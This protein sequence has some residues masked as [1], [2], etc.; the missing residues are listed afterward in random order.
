MS[1][2]YDSLTQAIQDYT[3]NTETSFVA[4]IDT[5]IKSSEERILKTVQLDLF[6]RNAAGLMTA[7]NKYLAKPSDFLS[8]FSLSLKTGG[9]VRFVEFKD[10]SFVQTFS[11]DESITGTPEYYSVFDINNFILGP[12]PNENL[13]VEI[14]YFY[15]PTSLTAGAGA[16]TTWLSENAEL[17]LL[18]GSLI[19]AYI[20]M[21]GESDILQMYDKR[22]QES[23]V[24]LKLFGESKENTQDYR[25]GR[26][27]L[28]KQ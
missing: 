6:K 4:N 22:F 14:H 1:F 8:P 10:V 21:K 19:E 3:E 16:G 12:T 18:Y 28:P 23:L 26:V 9:S 24:G 15:R 20:F 17:T 27:N 7:S 13:N 11:P 25:V 2:T 5:F